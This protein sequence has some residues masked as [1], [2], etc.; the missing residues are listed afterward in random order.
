[1]RKLTTLFI[2]VAATAGFLILSCSKDTTSPY[3]RK[4][5]R[6]DVVLKSSSLVLSNTAITDTVGKTISIGICTYLATYIDS[7]A[8]SVVKENGT[9]DTGFVIDN[10]AKLSDTAWY[11]YVSHSIGK[12]TVKGKAFL[13]D[14]TILSDSLFLTILPRAITKITGPVDVTADENGSAMFTL[15]VSGEGPFTYQWYK[16]TT[17]SVG[18]NSCTLTVAPVAGASA[19]LYSC[20]VTDKWG[21]TLTIGY[22]RL[23]VL[24]ISAPDSVKGIAAV[25]RID[26]S[27]TFSWNKAGNAESYI[28][29]RSTN[30]ATGFAPVDTTTDTTFKDK[31]YSAIYYYY[32]AAMNS[33]GLSLHSTTVFSASLN[34][35]PKWLH[36]TIKVAGQ[37]NM[38]ISLNL[39]DS[40]KDI[41]GDNVSLKLLDGG[42]ANDSLASSVWSYKPSY[43]DSGSYTVRISAS[44]G[45]DSSTLTLLLH[46]ANVNRKPEFRMDTTSFKI[47]SGSLLSFGVTAT[48]P[49]GD[50]ISYFIS[51]TTLPHAAPVIANRMV[52]WQSDANDNGNY[53]ITIGATDGKDM[54]SRIIQVAVGKVNAAP[55]L[56]AQYNDVTLAK[57]GQTLRVSEGDSLQLTFRISDPDSGEQF[58]LSMNN[59]ASLSCGTVVFDSANLSFTFTPSFNCAQKDSVLLSNITF[60]VTDNGVNGTTPAPL[61][62]TVKVNFNVINTNRPPAILVLQDTTVYQGTSLNFMAQAVDPDKDSVTLTASELSSSKLPDGASFNAKTGLF[63]WTPTFGQEGTYFIVFTAWDGKAGDKDTATIVVKKTDRPPVITVLPDTTLGKEGQMV[64]FQVTA[65]DPD[66]GQTVTVTAKGAPAA[67]SFTNNT[68][69]WT[70]NYGEAGNYTITFTASDGILKDSTTTTIKVS[71][72]DRPPVPQPQNLSC[73]RN[74]PLSITLTA[75]DPDGRAITGWAIDT[76]A[77]HGTA[78]LASAGQPSV[79]YTPANNF[80]GTDYFTFTASDIK[81]SSTFSARI[82][83]RVDTNNIA[84]RITQAL[85]VTPAAIN[86]GDSIVLT[87]GINSDAFPAPTLSWYKNGVLLVANNSTVWKKTGVTLS[88]SGYYYVIVSSDAG[89]DSSGCQ[90]TVRVA[91]AISPKLP[92][93]TF[94]NLGAGLTLAVTVNA[95]AFPAPAF[96]WYF[97]GTVIQGANSNS[98]SKSPAAALDAGNYYVIVSNPAGRDSSG[99]K[100]SVNI[101]PAISPKLPATT[102]VNRG[103]SLALSVSVNSDVSPAPAYAWYK[104]GAIIPGATSNSYSKNPVASSDTGSYY[105]IVSNA[106]GKDSSGTKVSVQVA[107]AISV[108]FPVNTIVNQGSTL[109]LGVTVNADVLPAPTYQWYKNGTLISAA[110]TATFTKAATVYADSGSYY[111]IVTNAAGR[112]SSGTRVKIRDITPPLI[113]L[114]GAVDTSILLGGTWTEPTGSYAT[115]D[116][117]G[118]IPYSPTW[119]SGTVNTSVIGKYVLTYT[120]SDGDTFAIVKRNISIGGIAPSFTTPLT[121]NTT[122]RQGS[123]LTLSVTVNANVNP[124]PTYIWYKNGVVIS[125]ATA[126]TYTKAATVYADSGNYAVV[127]Y[128]SIGRDSSVTKLKIRDITPPVI[129]LAGAVD[130]SILLGGTWTEPTG[131]YATDDRLGTMNYSPS[132]RSGTVNVAVLGANTLTYTVSDGDTFAIA[133]RIVRVTGTAPSFTTRLSASTSVRQGSTL[134]LSVTVNA[135]VSPAPTYIWYKNGVV[136]SGATS[137]TYTKA[138]AVYA[139]SGNY[140]VVAY[141]VVGRDSSFTKVTV[142]DVPPVPSPVSPA[143]GASG[144]PVSLTLL[145]NKT[146][147]TTSYHVQVS[148]DPGFTTMFAVD[149]LL[150]DTTKAVSGLSKGTTY[151]WRVR[152]KNATGVSAWSV[153]RI[154]TPIRQFALTISATNGSV[155]KLPD[156]ALYDSGAVV[157][158]SAVANAGNRFTGWS[159][160]LSGAVNPVNITMNGAKNVTAN[161]A[162]NTFTITSSAGSNGSITPNGATPVNFGA[163]QTYAITPA[164]GYHI[165]DVLVDGVSV[166]PVTTYTFTNVT[167]TH[168]ISVIF[169]I[170]TYT[171]T[172]SAGANGSISPNGT[173]SVN[174]GAN[175]T[176]TITPVTGFHVADVLVDGGSVGAVTSYPF[177][178]VTATH[179]ISA[180]FAID[181][182]TLTVTAGTGGTATPSSPTTV[183]YGAATPITASPGAGYKFVNWTASPSTGVSFGNANSSSTTVTLTSVGTT[184]TA[185]FQALTCSWSDVY[186]FSFGWNFYKI[187]TNGSTIFTG[188]QKGGG[189]FR[190][191]QNGDVD[192]WSALN[193]GG[194]LVMSV[195]QAGAYTFA[196][197]AGSESGIHVSPDNGATWSYP[198]SGFEVYSFTSDRGTIYAGAM[199]SGVLSSTDNGT[200]WLSDPA[201]ADL[202]GINVYAVLVNG[203]TVYAGTETGLYY[204]S[205]YHWI[206]IAAV[207]SVYVNALAMTGN[208]IFAGTASG[209]Y[210]LD[211][212]TGTWTTVNSGLPNTN[213]MSFVVSNNYLFAATDA[214]VS[215]TTNNGDNWITVNGGLPGGGVLARGLAVNSTHIFMASGSTIYRSPLP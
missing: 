154:F 87:V 202:Y 123:A 59:R 107:P 117:L 33:K 113:H 189:V 35:A 201:A 43:A 8:I 19:G 179:T 22:A 32:V 109:T 128:N 86:K 196:G 108:K 55:S 145:W 81:M 38:P 129:H 52:T 176:Y 142:N 100:V 125:G 132:W 200:N 37:E 4:N 119:V 166:G 204:R 193:V 180:T 65:T 89:R 174:Y 93:S 11:S 157:Q 63:S 184:V 140:A 188:A 20:L 190:S 95:D 161:F 197:A 187:A 127:A 158:L 168:T 183:N 207:P 192:T 39:A 61:S 124:A 42:P 51:S 211:N 169:A 148:S 71:H 78:V 67:S 149:S 68:F 206:N 49:D 84:P 118:N 199:G 208:Y 48:D 85:A 46:I 134:T 191:T 215:L 74:Q 155:T 171:I 96:A 79:T 103:A 182:Y 164:T 185:N 112:D 137:N 131:S 36:D 177:T 58:V 72:V 205:G 175:Q 170:N 94:V 13:N 203:S 99:T 45:M 105:V 120:V 122:V 56:S 25:S 144:L 147:F 18:A 141:N 77:T 172:A 30:P 178:N 82:T 102:A 10:P 104:N 98:Y 21:D 146:D 111:V 40:C 114:A 14:G 31:I 16:D 5:I 210:R 106:A 198:L 136:I 2:C 101:P 83:I 159:G 75:L 186:D 156:A 130:T 121:A 126:N 91:P 29:Y 135:N 181:T 209:V 41:N 7:I 53:S 54:A 62:D 15:Q 115:D 69:S 70:P 88:D 44:D 150:T 6:F 138:S 165:V 167:A 64:S 213:V 3:D 24:F 47:S 76:P 90:V 151:Y 116:R 1:M 139:D 60:I 57:E 73:R 66:A 163:N 23:S 80:M 133:T 110:T 50:V 162:I 17:V 173:T 143:D 26:G 195:Y 92:A 9:R 28:V 212:S 12:K 27:F 214:G 160:D 34:T 194:T 152:A 97:N 153:A